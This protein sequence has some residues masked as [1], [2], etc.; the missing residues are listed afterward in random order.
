M[1]TTSQRIERLVA[2]LRQSLAAYVEGAVG[3]PQLVS[4]V[5][6]LI[7]GLSEVADDDWVEEL[8]SNWWHLEFAYAMSADEQRPLSDEERAAVDEAVAALEAM[9]VAY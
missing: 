1:M 4:D 2:L 3:L 5:E 6:S 9:L 8:R 7:D